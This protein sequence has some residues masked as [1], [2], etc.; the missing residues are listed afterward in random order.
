MMLYICTN[1]Q[2][3]ICHG[4]DRISTLKTTKGHYFVS[5]VGGITVFVIYTL[6]LDAVLL[7]QDLSK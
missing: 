3:N 2:E 5:N 6:S 1:F 7:Y 4:V